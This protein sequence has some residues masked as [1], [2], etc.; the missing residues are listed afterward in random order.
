MK[1]FLKKKSSN[2]IQIFSIVNFPMRPEL[3]FF[4]VF[5]LLETQNW[6]NL[7][8][9][10]DFE[11]K[12]FFEK[13]NLIWVKITLKVNKIC[14]HTK[15]QPSITRKKNEIQKN[16]FLFRILRWTSFL[17]IPLTFLCD[18]YID[19]PKFSEQKNPFE[20]IVPTPKSGVGTIKLRR[21]AFRGCVFV[22]RKTYA[23]LSSQECQ[24][25]IWYVQDVRSL[26]VSSETCA[27][28]GLKSYQIWFHTGMGKIHKYKKSLS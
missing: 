23:L 25:E 2:R 21:G 3:V 22:T 14:V 6:F 17:M 15:L 20:Y 7:W 8:L 1:S 10:C 16:L 9:K 18:E 19:R 26:T 4:I 11:I 28:F 12:F 13:M 27:K 24:L 5:H